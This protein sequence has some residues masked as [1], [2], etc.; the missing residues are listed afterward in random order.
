[1][2]QYF[3]VLARYGLLSCCALALGACGNKGPLTLP[4]QANQPAA[5]KPSPATPAEKPVDPG[6]RAASK[7]T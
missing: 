1:M 4:T 7:P 5:I 3:T 6:G 2:K